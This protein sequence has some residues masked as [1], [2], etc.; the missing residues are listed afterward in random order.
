M[1]VRNTTTRWGFVAQ[2]LHWAIVVLIIL[3]FV[4]GYRAHWA[5]GLKKLSTVVPHKSWG[6]TILA[7]AVIRL[8]WRL[9]NPTPLLPNNLKPWERMAAH[10]THYGLYI[11]IFAMP[12]TG[13]IA[14]SA[15]GFSVSWAGIVQL[16]NFVASGNRPLYD[17]LMTVHYWL[18]WTLVAIAT[19]HIVAA[20][21]H[22]VVLKDNV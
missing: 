21:K 2:L 11:L 13:W 5:T 14:S 15:R 10:V 1:A 8:V 18:S 3:Q 19:L 4:L 16:P 22:H 20:L 7:L 17:S 12:L 6:I 9:A